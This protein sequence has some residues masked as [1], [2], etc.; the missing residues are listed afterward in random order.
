[1]IKLTSSYTIRKLELLD[2][3]PTTWLAEFYFGYKIT[4]K[5]VPI[6]PIFKVDIK[7][8][9]TIDYRDLIGLKN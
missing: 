8:Q 9:A 5:S 7:H 1:M 4:I 2:L 3:G 6:I